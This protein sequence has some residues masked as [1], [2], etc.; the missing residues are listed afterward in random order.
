[1]IHLRPQVRRP[2]DSDDPL[3]PRATVERFDLH[4]RIQHGLMASSFITLVL[5][6]WP[7]SASGIGASEGLVAFL[8]GIETCGLI[9]RVAAVGM[10]I[11]AIYHAGW[12][13]RLAWRGRLRLTMLPHPKDLR[14]LVGNLAWFVGARPRRPRFGRYS[15]FEKF[16][17]WAV[18]WGV[19]IM[20]GSGLLRWFP[21]LTV[22]VL[23]AWTYEIALHAH[24]DEAL[25][26]AL[27]IF[28]WHFYNVHLRPA[29]FPMSPVFIT[30]RVTLAELESEHGEEY[31]DLVQAL[32]AEA[33]PEAP[34]EE[35][36]ASEAPP[37]E[38][39]PPA[40]D[41]EDPPP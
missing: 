1:M 39:E 6:G 18:F 25:L 2:P 26:A 33:A 16:D 9:H 20:V 3:D 12:M 23:P 36:P 19:A 21:D 13:A 10:V 24:T 34:P 27:A 15:Y 40:D 35:P 14:D 7:L 4:Q 32:S 38:E 41:E 29:V 30:G 11:S 8:G 17:Y 31:D 28:M 37:P 5:T 22:S